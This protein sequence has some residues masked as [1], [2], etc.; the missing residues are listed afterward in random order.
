MVNKVQPERLGMNPDTRL[1][2]ETRLRSEIV[3][4]GGHPT[5]S[6]FAIPLTSF[7]LRDLANSIRLIS[8]KATSRELRRVQRDH[9]TIWAKEMAD[10]YYRP[11][12]GTT[13]R[14]CTVEYPLEMPLV[15]GTFLSHSRKPLK[16][17]TRF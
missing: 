12:A 15:T 10:M 2:R 17:L 4:G 6:F 13:T 14:L 11:A 16:S 8:A 9:G 7:D 3:G 1:T 5:P